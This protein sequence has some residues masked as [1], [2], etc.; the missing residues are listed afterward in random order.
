MSTQSLPAATDSPTLAPIGEAGSTHAVLR[1][2]WPF[3][4]RYRVRLAAA[5]VL[6]SLTTALG[7][8]F[9]AFFGRV[10][11]AAFTQQDPA[12]LHTHALLLVATLA[13]QTVLVF[14][15]HYSFGWVAERV[16]ADLR[17]A[18][19][20]H[21]LRQSQSFFHRHPTG[22]LLAR[23]HGDVT[24][25]QEMLATGASEGVVGVLTVVGGVAILFWTDAF[26]TLVMLLAVPP[27]IIATVHFGRRIRVM[28]QR[29]QDAL[30]DANGQLLEQLV[31]I[32]TV[33]SFTR[34]EH[35]ASRFGTRVEA[36]FGLAGRGLLI[37]SAF[38]SFATFMA[39]ATVFGVFWV[40]ST[41]V[42]RGDMTAGTLTEF[43]MYTVVVG[44]SVTPLSGLWGRMQAALGAASHVFE[45]LDVEP[46]IASPPA[47]RRPSTVRGEL[48][49]ERVSF[50]YPD[51]DKPVLRDVDLHLRPGRSCAL[52]G[53]SG[54]G[55]STVSRLLRRL[56]DPQAG[57]V[58][59]DGHD[60]RTLDL[61]ALRGS[62]A[63]VSQEP[64]LFSGSIGENIRYGRLDATD[65]EIHAAARLANAHAFIEE[66][67]LG[68]DTPVGEGGAQLSG[69]Q[70]QRVSIARAL[71][72]DPAILILDEATS[73]LD[74][75]SE[76]LVQEG[77][78]RLQRGRTTLIIA[79][80]LSTVMAADHIAVL[81]D[82]RIVEEGTHAR[83]LAQ[84]G[85]YAALV[86]RQARGREEPR[87]LDCA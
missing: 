62:I 8:V 60:L 63:V 11:D 68:Y 59:L 53:G 29:A 56:Y 84:N 74:A 77:L 37:G 41:A 50:A 32:E 45:L 46:E 12:G 52:V 26:L 25:V 66:L 51:R 14:L 78:E 65:D 30:A 38:A 75:H 28:G 83:L 6:L 81:D 58:L 15:R 24:K 2:L 19:S 82:G 70:R 3:V 4:A 48:R 16:I 34:E 33:Q 64:R 71:L 73:A 86:A 42:A 1:R 20:R 39:F 76:H 57:R 22:E 87:V 85:R 61:S 9:P 79:H 55:K 72:R 10:I 13:L 49:L 31:E 35:A 67:P 7:L 80:R 44:A 17:L 40:G 47:G 54:S 43:M 5:S 18:L 69:G 27:A 23:S 36:A 21:L